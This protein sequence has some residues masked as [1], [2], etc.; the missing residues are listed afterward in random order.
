MKV[1]VCLVCLKAID[2]KNLSQNEGNSPKNSEGVPLLTEFLKFTNNY[3]H[4]SA[5]ATTQLSGDNGENEQVQDNFCE[6]CELAL[7]NP[8]CQLYLDLLGTKLR[9]SWELGQLGK[10][11]ETSQHSTSDTL[12]EMNMNT[13]SFQLGME[14]VEDVKELKLLTKKCKQFWRNLCLYLFIRI[15]LFPEQFNYTLKVN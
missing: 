15:L 7:T 11:S 10:I 5:L 4:I 3:L 1:S 14:K 12:R 2:I 6:K 8:I 13:L 9:L